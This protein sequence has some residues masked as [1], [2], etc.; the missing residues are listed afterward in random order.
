M[1]AHQYVYKSMQ[2]RASKKNAQL[3]HNCICALRKEAKS[4]TFSQ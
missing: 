1:S 3:A 4:T 2:K